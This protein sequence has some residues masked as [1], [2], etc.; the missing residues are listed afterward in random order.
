M[1]STLISKK[2]LDEPRWKN[3]I[4]KVRSKL[5]DI[6][7]F[8]FIDWG[9]KADSPTGVFS[10]TLTSEQQRDF[11]RNVDGFCSSNGITFVY[12]IHGGFMGSKTE[13]KKFSFGK[14]T[15][16]DSLAPEFQTYETIKKLA[17]SK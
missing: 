12:P 15:I 16:Y 3:K 6:P 14:Y 13:I 4:A 17:Q 9:G 7:I 5:G 2:K 11:L 10:Q 8:A 1:T